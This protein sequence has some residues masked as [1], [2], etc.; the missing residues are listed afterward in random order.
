[1][2]LLFCELCRKIDLLGKGLARDGKRVE[3]MSPGW[4]HADFMLAGLTSIQ[5]DVAKED[6]LQN[7]C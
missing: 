5:G 7:S 2:N 3:L 4:R 1:M 6:I